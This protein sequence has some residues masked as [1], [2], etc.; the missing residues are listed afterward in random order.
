[1][2]SIRLLNATGGNAEGT[3]SVRFNNALR[4]EMGMD[5]G[6]TTK[7]EDPWRG[8]GE[9]ETVYNMCKLSGSGKVEG[10][11]DRDGGR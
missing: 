5:V 10:G 9:R 4:S 8:W 6:D 3:R 2:Q 11:G 7:V 1:M